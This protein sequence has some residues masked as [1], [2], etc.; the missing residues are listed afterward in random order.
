MDQRT[1]ILNSRPALSERRPQETGGSA[2]AASCNSVLVVDDNSGVREALISKI[3]SSGYSA[4]GAR[5]GDEALKVL[6]S[7]KAPTLIFLDL[8]MPKLNGWELIDIWKQDPKLCGNRIVLISAVN[9]KSRPDKNPIA[10]V[11][12]SILKPLSVKAVMSYVNQYCFAKEA[13][14][15]KDV[16]LLNAIVP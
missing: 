8:M 2:G 14:V 6:P 12:G 9:Q 10:N 15:G 7:L 11:A 5:S 4:F 13:A 3:A 16:I 1:E